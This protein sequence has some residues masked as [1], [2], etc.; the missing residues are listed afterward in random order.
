MIR[1]ISFWIWTNSEEITENLN[2]ADLFKVPF[3]HIRN[4]FGVGSERSSRKLRYIH[5]NFLWCH[6]MFR[7]IFLSFPIHFIYTICTKNA[8]FYIF[9]QIMKT[10]LLSCSQYK[11]KEERKLVL[12]VKLRSGDEWLEYLLNNL[13][14]FKKQ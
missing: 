11:E 6:V 9:C 8:D 5:K 13:C 1:D 7:S 3:F 4:P 2:R 10:L 12:R 14:N